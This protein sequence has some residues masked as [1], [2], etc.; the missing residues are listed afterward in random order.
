[1]VGQLNFPVVGE[2]D[3]VCALAQRIFELGRMQLAEDFSMIGLNAYKRDDFG[4]LRYQLVCKFFVEADQIVD[5]DIA[6]VFLEER[7]LS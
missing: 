4:R 7:I 1:M 6:E 2:E 3:S 5:V